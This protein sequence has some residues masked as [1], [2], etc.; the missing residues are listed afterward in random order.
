[1]DSDFPAGDRRLGLRGE[2][3]SP[4]MGLTL[5][6]LSCLKVDPPP[7]YL[8]LLL[9]VPETPSPLPG[10]QPHPRQNPEGCT[11]FSRHPR[12]YSRRGGTL[13]ASCTAGPPRPGQRPAQSGY[14]ATCWTD[15]TSVRLLAAPRDCSPGWL[16]ESGPSPP[17]GDHSSDLLPCLGAQRKR[18]RDQGPDSVGLS[19]YEL[20]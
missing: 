15:G 19:W 12:L 4:V 5:A 11:I 3:W 13:P 1:M 7:C 2:T 10:S 6:H 20:V 17:F 18:Q 14:S 8:A 9:S 16:P